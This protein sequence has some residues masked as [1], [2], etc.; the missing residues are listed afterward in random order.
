MLKDQIADQLTIW[1]KPVLVIMA[2]YGARE[3]INVDKYLAWGELAEK[4]LDVVLAAI[5]AYFA[6]RILRARARKAEKEHME[7]DLKGTIKD[8]IKEELK[9]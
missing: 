4:G 6:Y 8:A 2:G 9:K 5:T 1:A 3:L 7:K